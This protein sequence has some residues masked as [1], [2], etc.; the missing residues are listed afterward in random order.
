MPGATLTPDHH[1]SPSVSPAR[2]QQAQLI[3]TRM[4]APEGRGSLWFVHSAQISAWHT[5]GTLSSWG[6]NGSGLTSLLAPSWFMIHFL[7]QWTPFRGTLFCATR[8]RAPASPPT[9]SISASWSA[10]PP[11]ACESSLRVLPQSLAQPP[12]QPGCKSSRP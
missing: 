9:V 7:C 2:H 3:P 6:M 12:S 11:A 5:V 1:V 4:H 8:P 10:R